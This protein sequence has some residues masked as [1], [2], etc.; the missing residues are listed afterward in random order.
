MGLS[1][2]HK[3]P[4]GPRL[5]PVLSHHLLNIPILGM[6]SGNPAAHLWQQIFGLQQHITDQPPSQ[7]VA[8]NLSH[9][10]D[11]NYQQKSTRGHYI[12][13]VNNYI[14]RYWRYLYPRKYKYIEDHTR[15]HYDEIP[16][17]KKKTLGSWPKILALGV[18]RIAALGPGPRHWSRWSKNRHCHHS[19]TNIMSWN[20][21]FHLISFH[22]VPFRSFRQSVSRFVVL[23]FLSSLSCSSL[24]LILLISVLAFLVSSFLCRQ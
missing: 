21:S 23:A 18:L 5:H 11:Q 15:L 19:I 13:A 2:F 10:H 7:E 4:K 12:L 1:E 16:P 24:L 22:C 6:Y 8:S 3:V 20:V 9:K 14:R 17:L